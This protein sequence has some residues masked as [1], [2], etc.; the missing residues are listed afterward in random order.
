M[1]T[2][3]TDLWPTD[4]VVDVLSPTMILN[5]QAEALAKR[6]QGIVRGEVL[7]GN[8]SDLEQLTFDLVAPAIGNRQRLLRVRYAPDLP[9]PVVLIASPLSRELHEM[10]LDAVDPKAWKLNP[11]DVSQARLAHTP[12][13]MREFLKRIFNAPTTRSMLFSFV[14]RSN[15]FTRRAMGTGATNSPVDEREP[16]NKE[17]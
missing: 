16:L 14:A 5:E 8:S 11:Q 13:E 7:P 15:E 6:T 2:D 17:E 4:L 12:N 1:A 9:Y 3:S 10:L